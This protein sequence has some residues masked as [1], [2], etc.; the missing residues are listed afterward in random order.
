MTSHVSRKT[1]DSPPVTLT[2]RDGERETFTAHAYRI[3]EVCRRTGLSR[4]TIYA[5]IKSRDLIARKYG[6][7]TIVLADDL[8]AFLRRLPAMLP[9]S[10]PGGG[11][12]CPKR[13]SGDGAA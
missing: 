13:M 12:G 4:T 11:V 8:E 2:R 9:R 6:R 7:V 1:H 3:P 5:A 10:G